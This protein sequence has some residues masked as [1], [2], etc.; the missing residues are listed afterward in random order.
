MKHNKLFI[1][2]LLVAIIL[3]SS[4]YFS[5]IKGQDQDYRRV[6]LSVSGG[7]TFANEDG[8]SLFES[9]FNVPTETSGIL[10]IGLQYAITPAWSLEGGYSYTQI[11]ASS[12]DFTTDMNNITLKNI[13]NLNQILSFNRVSNSINPYLTVGIGYDLYNYESSSESINNNDISYN[14]GA[15]IAFKASNTIDLFTHYEYNIASNKVDNLIGGQGNNGFGSDVLTNLTGG[16]RINFGDK[17]TTHPSWR[18]V[19]VEVRPERYE[20]L[21]SQDKLAESLKQKV[22]DLEKELEL[23]DKKHS[24][25]VSLYEQRI[26]SLNQQITKLQTQLKHAQDSL[27]SISTSDDGS[28]ERDKSISAGHYV[29]VFATLG[30]ESAKDVMSKTTSV[31]NDDQNYDSNDLVFIAKRKQFYEVLIGTFSDYQKA[32]EVLNMMKGVYGDSFIITF[33]RPVSL[34]ELYEDISVI[35]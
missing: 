3:F 30:L 20:Y 4:G 33:P 9:R 17:Q 6:S 29:Q 13:F 19:P 7:A 24:K 2:G 25:Q 12:G 34:Q 35:N 32:Q 18:P 14:L 23:Q 1:T 31:L 16:I 27:A 22:A 21:V 28:A 10:G 11:R 15:G 26:D 5:L 8:F